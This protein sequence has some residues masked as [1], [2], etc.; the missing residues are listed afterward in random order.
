MKLV[1]LEVL[2]LKWD[3]ANSCWAACANFLSFDATTIAANAK[4]NKRPNN[5]KINTI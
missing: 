3:E 1:Y 5:K 4:G 2:I